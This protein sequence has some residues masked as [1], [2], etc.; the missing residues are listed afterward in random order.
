MEVK[1]MGTETISGKIDPAVRKIS[2][3]DVGDALAQGLRD[4]RSAPRYGLFLGGLCAIIGIVL[5]STLFVV[6]M[7]Y[8]AYPIVAGFAIVCPSLAAGLYEVSRRLETGEKISAGELWHKIVGRSEVRWMGFVTVFVFVIWMYQVRTLLALFLGESGMGASLAE[9]MQTVLTTTPGL[10]F[11][12]LGNIIG[13]ID[14]IL[15]FSL[16]VV[17]FPLVLDRDVDVVT[18]MA[19]SVQA[20]LANPKPMLLFAGVIVLLLLVSALTGFIGLLVTMPILGHATWHL[21]RKVVAPV[22]AEI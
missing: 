9:F 2:S 8:L 16:S 10:I 18:A 3:G 17:S 5:V 11:L 12:L 13:V 20:V 14:S 6:G 4:F 1:G 21:Y 15:L 22:M 19:M 7:P